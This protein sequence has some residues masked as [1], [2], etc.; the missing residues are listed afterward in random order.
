MKKLFLLLTAALIWTQSEA[1][2]VTPE[3]A[4]RA[5]SSFLA[6]QTAQQHKRKAAVQELQLAYTAMQPSLQKSGEN[7]PC[8]YSFNRKEGGFVIVSA[9]QNIVPIL[10]YGENGSFDTTDL[11]LNMKM[12]LAVMQEEIAD[13]IRREL[14]AAPSVTDKWQLLESGGATI[15]VNENA[16]AVAPLTQNMDWDQWPY[17]NDSCPKDA[18]VSSSYGGRC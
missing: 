5:G 17:F 14:P 18:A 16:T 6:Q 8:F 3:T 12:L 11:P 10:A 15:M 9:S 1:Q 2:Y 7:L 4:A 13:A